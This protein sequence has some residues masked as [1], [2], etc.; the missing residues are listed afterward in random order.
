MQNGHALADLT[1]SGISQFKGVS[2]TASLQAIT[3]NYLAT[4]EHDYNDTNYH[5]AG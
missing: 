3:E 1:Q 2:Y 4:R 5:Y